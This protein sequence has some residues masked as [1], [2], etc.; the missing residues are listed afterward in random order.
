MVDVVV[1]V[2][3]A[4]QDE[5]FLI[6]Q[7][8][9]KSFCNGNAIVCHYTMMPDGIGTVNNLFLVGH[10]SISKIGELDVSNIVFF[11]N[12]FDLANNANIFL[13]GCSTG[14]PN[15]QVLTD[16]FYAG[17]PLASKMREWK[18]N[19]GIF[20]TRSNVFLQKTEG[21]LYLRTNLNQGIVGLETG[22]N[23]FA[24]HA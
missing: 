2:G 19:V 16:G 5:L 24:R 8:A 17:L 14:N 20:Y 12:R 10:G 6:A 21:K 7:S 13:C 9:D 1:I 4:L 11:I 3:S 15:Q 18:K 23:I 22:W